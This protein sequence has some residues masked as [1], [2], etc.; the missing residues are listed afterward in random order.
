MNVALVQ[1]GLHTIHS[2]LS[3]SSS[4]PPLSLAIYLFSDT[5]CVATEIS[6]GLTRK[7]HGYTYTMKYANCNQ[8]TKPL[9]NVSEYIK[10]NRQRCQDGEPDRGGCH[11]ISRIMSPMRL[12]DDSKAAKCL[13]CN[14]FTSRT[15]HLESDGSVCMC[16]QWKE[17]FPPYSPVIALH[18]FLS[19]REWLKEYKKIA[20]K[21]N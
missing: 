15:D 7:K 1:C 12:P 21:K 14:Y 18:S 20:Q 19:K 13:M 17:K 8:L 11:W 2:I 5:H 6:I 10:W 16:M 4:P 3:C 9:N